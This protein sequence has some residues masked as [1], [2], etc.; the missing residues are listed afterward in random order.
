MNGVTLLA[1]HTVKAATGATPAQVGYVSGGLAVGAALFWWFGWKKRKP[2]EFQTI[3][4]F[5]FGATVGGAVG[6][7]LHSGAVHTVNTADRVTAQLAGHAAVSVIGAFGAFWLLHDMWPK[8][9]ADRFVPF[10][11]VGL[12]LIGAVIPGPVGDVIRSLCASVP[13]LFAAALYQHG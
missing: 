7:L 8:N 4:A 3:F 11:A 12:P 6:R 13:R 5:I 10:I 9:Q 2:V 1:A